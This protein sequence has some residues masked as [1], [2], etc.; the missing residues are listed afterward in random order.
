MSLPLAPFRLDKARLRKELKAFQK[1]LGPDTKEL[2]EQADI[3]PF[4]RGNRN[5]ASLLGQ[6]NSL[7]VTPDLFKDEFGLI[8]D[9]ACDLAVGNAAS[10]QF[11]FV[12]FEDAGK[13]SVFR[14]GKKAAPRWGTRIE[15]GFSQLLD[16][17]Y[18]LEDL[19]K[20]AKFRT[21][22]GSD[23]ADYVGLLIVGRSG[24][25]PEATQHRLRWRS[26]NVLVGGKKIKCLTFDELLHDLTERVALLS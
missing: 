12:E 8:G 4:F 5:L 23:L 14:G 24:H 3:L 18:V 1:L 10:G 17:F 25:L 2:G 7:L 6:H 26:A 15:Q 16:W 13:T 21:L 19:R 22:F 11:C 9:H 20:T